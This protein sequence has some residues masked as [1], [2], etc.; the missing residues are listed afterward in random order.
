LSRG[1][2][3]RGW[4]ALFAGALSFVAAGVEVSTVGVQLGA[5]EARP[6]PAEPRR[7]VPC[8]GCVLVPA[9]RP[10]VPAPLLVLLH[11]DEGN[12]SVILPR[13]SRAARERGH[14]VLALR[15]PQDEGCS[16]GSWWRWSGDPAWITRQIDA[17]A[18]VI[19]VDRSRVFLS[20]WS[21]GASYLGLVAPQLRGIA[22]LNLSG[23]G[24]PPRDKGCPPCQPPVYFLAGNG[25]PLHHLAVAAKDAF[26]GCGSE[27]EWALLSGK[28]H[29][30][31]L[32]ALDARRTGQIL[33]W[34]EAHAACG[35][36]APGA[37]GSA[38]ASAIS[39]PPAPSAVAPEPAA[40]PPA[41]PL[42]SAA[43]MPTQRGG[44]GSD[45][46]LPPARTPGACGCRAAGGGDPGA[47]AAFAA[48]AAVLAL[49]RGRR[50]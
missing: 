10:E 36:A 39:A 48:L 6:G 2:S 31:E 35:D 25:N 32:S 30:G 44:K 23:G 43:A 27:V 7:N 14:A 50:R 42:G 26:L 20:G 12:P 46:N 34:L 45:T 4:R 19:A 29:G 24:L 41:R 22:G 47:L 37:A 18:R 38:A 11:G 17:A 5:A 33:A 15:C 9:P 28:D 1:A 13:W 49:R 3:A 40:L 21:G 16:H 8:E